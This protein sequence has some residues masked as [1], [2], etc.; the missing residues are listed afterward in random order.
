[1]QASRLVAGAGMRVAAGGGGM[2]G[3]SEGK[4][5]DERER[6]GKGEE[7]TKVG[8]TRPWIREAFHRARA[9]AGLVSLRL[10]GSPQIRSDPI[11]FQIELLRFD[12]ID[13]PFHRTNTQE[14]QTT[15][16]YGKRLWIQDTA[17]TFLANACH[18]RGLISLR[19]RKGK[20]YKEGEKETPMG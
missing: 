2:E 1:M 10:V 5:R 8:R 13:R 6:M 17:Q 20:R 7:E 11:R 19:R 16:N 18:G 3:G 15:D 9:G 4:G 12:R 14:T